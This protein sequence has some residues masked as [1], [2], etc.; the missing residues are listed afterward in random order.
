[1]KISAA[2]INY[3][4]SDEGFQTRLGRTL[5]KLIGYR[6]LVGNGKGSVR[7]RAAEEG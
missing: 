3:D 7:S 4:V 1:M 6:Q 2:L 5:G